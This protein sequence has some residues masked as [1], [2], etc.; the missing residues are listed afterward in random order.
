MYSGGAIFLQNSSLLAKKCIFNDNSASSGGFLL[1]YSSMI[2]IAKCQIAN[3]MADYIQNELISVHSSINSTGYASIAGYGGALH[4]EKSELVVEATKFLNNTAIRN[5]GVIQAFHCSSV[6]FHNC[7]FNA[8][9]AQRRGG[10]ISTADS[11]VFIRN[12]FFSHN[13]AEQ[14]GSLFIISNSSRNDELGRLLVDRCVFFGNSAVY[15]G[16]MCVLEGTNA[17]LINSDFQANS[18]INTGGVLFLDR[19]YVVIKAS[20]FTHSYAHIGGVIHSR[21]KSTLMVNNSTFLFNNATQDA[22]ALLGDQSDVLI[23]DSVFGNNT[24]QWGGAVVAYEKAMI[25]I[26][27]CLLTFN[28]AL[29]GGGLAVHRGS[30]IVNGSTFNH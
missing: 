25:T 18:A 28:T 21:P 8:N 20:T 27:R 4:I 26:N 14:G 15:G 22:G 17:T 10:A 1:S 16:A 2:N 13:S 6:V 7:T 19:A 3:N 29:W 23:Q 30:I 11:S 24:A 9:L 12:V 5:G